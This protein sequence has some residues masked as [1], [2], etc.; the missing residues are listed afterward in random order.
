RDPSFERY[1]P[2]YLS[3]GPQ[4]VIRKADSDVGY[5]GRTS[6]DVDVPASEVESV[7][8]VRNPTLTHLVDGDQRNVELPIVGRSGHR[9][10]VSTPPDGNVAP[11]G[12]YMLFVNVRGKSCG[13]LVPSRAAQTFVGRRPSG[14]A[15]LAAPRGCVTKPFRARVNGTGIDRV[16]FFVD[17]RRVK[18]V[19]AAGGDGSFT[20]RV[21]PRRLRAG[22]A[23]RLAAKVEFVTG[24]GQAAR[25]L[26]TTF[27]RCA[28]ARRGPVSFT[29]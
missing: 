12:P 16:T 10:T 15:K 20:A 4:P 8:L 24:A 17:G 28:R 5:G 7:V 14:T 9:V 11:P 27:R 18:R 1:T 2:P 23:H 22:R 3:C 13:K 26:R 25:T 6:I 19:S 21:D 29:G